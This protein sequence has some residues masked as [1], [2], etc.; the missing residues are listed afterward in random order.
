MTDSANSGLRGALHSLRARLREHV[1]DRRRALRRAARVTARLPLAVAPLDAGQEAQ[2]ELA[3]VRALAGATRD[4]SG[5]G[6]TLLLP[7]VRVGNRYLT[8]REGY[9]GVR[10]DLPDGPLCLIAAPARFEQLD[11]GAHGY[12]FLLAVRIVKM[13]ESEGARYLAYLSTLASNERRV[14]ER[15]RAG[16]LVSATSVGE[17][18]GWEGVTPVFISEA[19]S[20]FARENA[21]P[22]KS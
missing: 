1:G 8:D 3:G 2:P 15:R 19:F 21:R 11:A 5:T 22:R 18:S 10:L 20:K 4:L 9:L 7:A 12:G 16:A 17:V 14:A 6:L 13:A